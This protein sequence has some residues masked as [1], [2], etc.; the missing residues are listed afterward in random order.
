[1]YTCLVV[2]IFRLHVGVGSAAD[3]AKEPCLHSKYTL[4]KSPTTGENGCERPGERVDCAWHWRARGRQR[5]RAPRESGATAGVGGREGVSERRERADRWIFAPAIACPQRF[6]QQCT[7]PL[8]RGGASRTASGQSHTSP[9]STA[10]SP[11]SSRPP[12]RRLPRPRQ[13]RR[14]LGRV[15]R[16]SRRKVVCVFVCVHA[17]ARRGRKGAG[18]RVSYSQKWR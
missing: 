8:G 3:A 14:R 2:Y 17:R 1:V 6:S 12:P 4:L 15:R 11:T 7:P 16:P 5:Q 10:P 18:A 9:S 13:E